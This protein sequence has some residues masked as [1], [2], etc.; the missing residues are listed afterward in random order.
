MF[1]TRTLTLALTFTLSAAGQ[2][3]FN[4]NLI[5]HPGAEAGPARESVDDPKVSIPNWTTT[6]T[7]TAARYDGGGFIEATAYGPRDRGAKY[8]SITEQGNAS[9]GTE[10]ID[11]LAAS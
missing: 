9:T 3:V 10:T 4:R 2:S 5:Q 6:G 8:F 7:M 11:I 1:T